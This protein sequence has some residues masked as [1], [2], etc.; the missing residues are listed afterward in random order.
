M[1]HHA[2]HYL[3]NVLQNGNHNAYY[4]GRNFIPYQSNCATHRILSMAT[5]TNVYLYRFS[6]GQ[7]AQLDVHVGEKLD[8]YCPQ[9][10]VYKAVSEEPLYLKVIK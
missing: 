1:N 10:T 3:K 8:I 5:F 9:R 7:Y 6:K 2:W 4:D